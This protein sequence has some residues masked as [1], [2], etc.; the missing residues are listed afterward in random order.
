MKY[1]ALLR[2][3]NV[4]GNNKVPMADLRECLESVGLQNVQ[5]Y[6]NSGNVLFESEKLQATELAKVCLETM[7]KRFGFPINCVVIA[8]D[9]FASMVASAP[10][11]WG[12]GEHRSDALFLIPPVT[13]QQVLDAVGPVNN[14]FE[15]L[16]VRDGVVFW[17]L[18]KTHLTRGRL[19]R[20]IGGDVYKQLTIRSYTTTHKL[21]DLLD[22]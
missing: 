14:E 3:I 11:Y 9:D 12:A 17:T 7:A 20:M 10:S 21:L 13:G 5:T 22:R 15:W 4:G 16:D 8:A 6:I 1:I 18:R 19:P 2:G